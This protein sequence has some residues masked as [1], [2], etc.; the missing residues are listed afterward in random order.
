MRKSGH[1]YA[2]YLGAIGF[3]KSVW[4]GGKLNFGNRGFIWLF[5]AYSLALYHHRFLESSLAPAYARRV[6]GTSAGSQIIVGGSNFGKLF[7]ALTVFLLSNR[8]PTPLPWL[9]VDA[10]ALNI[11]WVLPA[12]SKITQ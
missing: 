9:R 2:V 6:L 3:F 12:F 8:V 11:V 5:P 4:V 10:L 1:L 7:G